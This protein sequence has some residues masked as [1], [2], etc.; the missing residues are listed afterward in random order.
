MGRRIGCGGDVRARPHALIAAAFVVPMVQHSG[1]PLEAGWVLG[2]GVFAGLLPDLDHGGS[3]ISKALRPVSLVWWPQE[4]GLYDHG[5]SLVGLHYTR[6][7]CGFHSL[8]TGGIL[9][10]ML[11]A[12]AGMLWGPGAFL[13]ALA[14]LVGWISHDLA[15]LATESG[16]MLFWPHRLMVR[17][18]RWLA[19]KERSIFGHGVEFVV[20][21]LAVG[22]MAY[23][24]VAGL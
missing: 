6:H 4:R 14:F 7:R 3:A 13:P 12:A 17:L 23:E 20:S 18:P 24:V 22:V 21:M 1:T 16:V 2:A 15:D 5:R 9:A 10:F 8:L 19:V 11:L